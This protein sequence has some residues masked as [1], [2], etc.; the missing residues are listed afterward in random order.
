MSNAGQLAVGRSI[1]NLQ[2]AFPGSLPVTGCD[3]LAY[4][5][6]AARDLHPLPWLRHMAKTRKPKDISKNKRVEREIYR[7]AAVEVKWQPSRINFRPG[8]SQETLPLPRYPHSPRQ[9]HR[10]DPAKPAIPLDSARHL[11]R[12]HPP[13]PESASQTASAPAKTASE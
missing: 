3:F 13:E 4:S 12:W 11:H 9:I 2:A 10:Y 6:A 1:R 8:Y 7:A 5:C